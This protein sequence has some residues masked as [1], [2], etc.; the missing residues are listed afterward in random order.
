MCLNVLSMDDL[1]L[2]FNVIS[3][4]FARVGLVQLLTQPL[5]CQCT[6]DST[7]TAGF[8]SDCGDVGFTDGL[9]SAEGAVGSGPPRAA[10]EGKKTDKMEESLTCIICQ[11]LLH[12]CVR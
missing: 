7:E 8:T 1:V 10:L 9:G 11:D 2:K 12:D 3:S 5:K 4:Q 6:K